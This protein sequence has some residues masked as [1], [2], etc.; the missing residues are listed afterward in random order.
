MSGLERSGPGDF[1]GRED[2]NA[3]APNAV[4]MSQ[5]VAALLGIVAGGLLTG[6]VDLYVADRERN[7]SARA[8]ARL[9]FADVMRVKSILEAALAEGGWWDDFIDALLRAEEST[10]YREQLAAG[11]AAHDFTTVD[12]AFEQVA[13]A[14]AAR[15]VGIDFASWR[16][17][18]DA[19][20]SA[21]DEASGRILKASHGRRG[22]RKDRI[23]ANQHLGPDSC[24]VVLYP[25]AFTN[26][27]FP[28]AAY[29]L[30]AKIPYIVVNVGGNNLTVQDADQTYATALSHEM[31][32]MVVDPLASGP[33]PEVCDGCAENCLN[34]TWNYFDDDGRFLG[35]S[36]RNPPGYRYAFYISA[37]AQPPASL[38]CPKRVR[39]V[40]GSLKPTSWCGYAP[41]GPTKFVSDATNDAGDL[42]VLV[43][44]HRDGLWH[45]VRRADGRWPDR[46][47]DVQE[48]IRDHGHPDVGPTRFVAST[49][50]RNGDLHTLV[51][52]EN[53][54]LWHTIR[55]DASGWS[56]PW[57]DVQQ[58]IRDRGHP[59][60]GPTKFVA[61]RDKHD[62]S[63]ACA[64]ARRAGWAVAHH[65]ARRHRLG[66]P[67]GGC[68]AAH[69]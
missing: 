50:R 21:L 35:S 11:V 48:R 25:A 47:E 7:A 9:M 28:P 32:E 10:K 63:S 55:Y 38:L 39:A 33:N 62:R 19:A 57:Q 49:T 56:D 58:A 44:D 2:F 65:L 5:L 16:L 18:I 26:V 20:V 12:G 61:K 1:A 53:D 66:R 42:H 60:V 37:I 30:F 43:L 69:S 29:H 24:V 67:L 27:D 23:T 59:D 36:K 45:T 34:Q 22:A 3:R 51:L 46:W 6:A 40:T 15:A 64:R 52:D 68:P 8:A 13:T 41:S 17:N 31:A 14:Q 4:V 54:G